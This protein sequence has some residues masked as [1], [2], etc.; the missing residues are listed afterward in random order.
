MK[1]LAILRAERF[2]PNSVGRDTAIMKAVTE[3]LQAYG[4]EVVTINEDHLQPNHQIAGQLILSMGRL[5]AT[6]RWLEAQE[7]KVINTPQSVIR[8]RRSLLEQTMKRCGV[9]V[10]PMEGTH[11]YWLKRSDSSAQTK[12]DIVF[13][14]D[15]EEL[16]RKIDD[17]HQRGIDDYTVSAHIVGDVVKFYGVRGTGFFHHYYPTDDGMSK[18]GNEQFNGRAHHYKF[19]AADLQQ[20]SERLAAAVGI[21]VYGGDCIVKPDGTFCL[22][23]F[24]DW[25]S[26][27]RCREEAADAIV[28]LII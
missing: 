19:K 27:S 9:P 21:D 4:H 17:F 15:K 16:K 10:P 8:C 5:P 28:K 3:R 18:F 25:P 23:D 20:V 11:G 1:V 13:C 26:F 22:I 14:S 7:A 6:L 24:N 12:D 2:S